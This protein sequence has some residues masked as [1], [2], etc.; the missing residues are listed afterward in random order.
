MIRSNYEYK[1][2]MTPEHRVLISNRKVMLSAYINNIIGSRYH[3]A[4]NLELLLLKE[5]LNHHYA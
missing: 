2:N 5:V 1:P 3:Y 4:G